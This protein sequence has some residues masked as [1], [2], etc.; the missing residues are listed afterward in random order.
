MHSP[1]LLIPKFICAKQ[2]LGHCRIRTKLL[3]SG[4]LCASVTSVMLPCH[5]EH[6][7]S[8]KISTSHTKPTTSDP[9]SLGLSLDTALK[10]TAYAPFLQSWKGIRYRF[11]TSIATSRSSYI[12]SFHS[13]GL[14]LTKIH[15]QQVLNAPF[16]APK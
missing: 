14:C 2:R 12:P 11:G 3:S 10:M 9:Q 1:N 5:F 4:V 6:H 15:Q 13:V 16:P 7:T 8:L